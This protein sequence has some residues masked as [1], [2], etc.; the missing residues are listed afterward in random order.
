MMK[1]TFR[2]LWQVGQK[3]YFIILNKKRRRAME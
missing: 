1:P 3:V 2:K